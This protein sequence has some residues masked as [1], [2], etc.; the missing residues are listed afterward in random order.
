[1]IT[2]HAYSE[3]LRITGHEAEMLD[4]VWPTGARRKPNRVGNPLLYV[5]EIPDVVPNGASVFFPVTTDGAAVT[6]LDAQEAA[7]NY[8][9]GRGTSIMTPLAELLRRR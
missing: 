9:L 6:C 2:E 3:W 7:N 5:W 4:R 8:E 1:M